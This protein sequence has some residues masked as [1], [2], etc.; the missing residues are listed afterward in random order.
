MT[1]YIATKALP[2]TMQNALASVGYHRK[3]IAVSAKERVSIQCFGGDGYRA[4]AIILNYATGEH[5]T[6]WGSWGGPNAFNPQNRVDTDSQEH[7]IPVNGAVILGRIGG[8]QPVSASIY[9]RPDAI[10]AMLPPAP[11]VTDEEK[12]ILAAYRGLKSGPYRQEAIARVKDSAKLIDSLV[13]RGFLKRSKNKAIQLT[14]E[15][16][17]A[18]LGTNVW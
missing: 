14:T 5:Q 18:S 3:D 11:T 10:T 7:E 8:D 9:V 12:Q 13:E 4:F 2:A 6:L 1:T 17:N 16:R 15:G